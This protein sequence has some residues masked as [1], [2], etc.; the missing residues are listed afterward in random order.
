MKLLFQILS[1]I[2]GCFIAQTFLP[3]WTMAI[4]AFAFGYYFNLSSGLSFLAGFLSVGLLW[5][6]KAFYI[7][8]T[9]QS[10]LT[11]KINKL[12]PLN[13]FVLMII[14][15]GLVGG[16]AALTGTILKGKKQPRYY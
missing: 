13:V 15:G 11:E 5:L 3:W 8:I 12:M 4:V 2:V 7:D 10:I 1:T 9:T 16:F 6:V 14:V